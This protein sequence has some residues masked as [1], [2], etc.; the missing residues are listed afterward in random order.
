MRFTE[1]TQE[2]ERRRQERWELEHRRRVR[3]SWIGV[4]VLALVGACAAAFVAGS[5]GFGQPAKVVRLVITSPLPATV[6]E[7]TVASVNAPAASQT[8]TSVT[9]ASQQRASSKASTQSSGG[10]GAVLSAGATTS[11]N[12]FERDLAGPVGVALAPVNGSGEIVLGDDDAAHGWSTTKV[13][14][15]A[16]LLKASSGALTSTEQQEAQ[17][18]ITESDNQSILDLFA[19]LE[20]IEGGLTGASSYITQLFRASG[21]SQ[22]VVATAPPPAGAVTTFG[23]TEWAPSEAVLFFRALA[24]GCLLPRSQTSYLLGLMQHIIPSESWGLGSAGF[25]AIAFKGGWGPENG[26]YLVRQ[27]GIIDPA[28]PQAVAVSIVTRPPPGGDSFSVGTEMVTQTATW[29]AH[30]VVLTPRSGAPC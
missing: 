30:H 14:V 19:D 9:S 8:A 25:P 11:F 6:P 20:Q 23:Q 24:G 5:V 13:P 27:S 18:A 21:D 3:R 1:T 10:S 26:G 29:L 17:L 22:T 12:A 16:A 7:Q 2:I 4:W 15:L 28:S